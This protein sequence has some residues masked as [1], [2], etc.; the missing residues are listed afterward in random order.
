M[1]KGI[2]AEVRKADR[3]RPGWVCIEQVQDCH[4]SE[5]PL[6]CVEHYLNWGEEGIHAIDCEQPSKVLSFVLAVF[7][8][9]GAPFSSG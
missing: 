7:F 9:S 6:L 2:I 5:Y 1:G 4:A 8:F 3:S